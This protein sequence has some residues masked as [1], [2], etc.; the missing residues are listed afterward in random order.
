MIYTAKY[1]L[2]H[3]NA[4]LTLA[5]KNAEGEQE[6]IGSQKQWDSLV[7]LE[8]VDEMVIEANRLVANDIN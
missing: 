4:G 3:F 8:Q 5:S 7:N 2:N 6:W 1:W